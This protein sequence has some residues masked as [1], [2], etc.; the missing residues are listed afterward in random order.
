LNEVRKDICGA[1]KFCVLW[2][3]ASETEAAIG[4]SAMKSGDMFAETNGLYAI[5]SRNKVND[6]VICYEPKSGC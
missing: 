2:F 5:Y 6:Q 3:Y 1:N 4:A